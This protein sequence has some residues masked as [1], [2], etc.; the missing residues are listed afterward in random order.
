MFDDSILDPSLDWDA[1]QQQ[2]EQQQARIAAL[3]K[4]GDAGP[5][6][7]QQQ[8]G[9]TSAVTG[10]HMLAAAPH[11]SLLQAIT[12]IASSFLADRGDQRVA[13]ATSDLTNAENQQVQDVMGNLPK[14]TP[15]QQATPGTPAQ[16]MVP[17]T[18]TYGPTDTDSTLITKTGEGTD[19]TMA[20]AATAGTPFKPAVPASQ[21]DIMTAL[22]PLMKNPLGRSLAMKKMEDMAIAEPERQAQ[23]EQAAATAAAAQAQKHEEFLQRQQDT[24]TNL[25]AG[26]EN[27]R[28]IAEGQHSATVEA[29]RLRADA[30]GQKTITRPDGLG[31]YVVQP[32]NG[33]PSHYQ[34]ND[35][36]SLVQGPINPKAQQQLFDKANQQKVA[37]RGIE[38]INRY[39]ELLKNEDMP[40]SVLGKSVAEVKS[41]LGMDT[42][43][44]KLAKQEAAAIA[45]DSNLTM[46][47][48][49]KSNKN[50]DQHNKMVGDL[51]DPGQSAKDRLA[52]AEN[53]KKNFEYMQQDSSYI[54]PLAITHDATKA[55]DAATGVKPSN[56]PRA[57]PPS[58]AGGSPAGVPKFVNTPDGVFP[59]VMDQYGRP[60]ANGR[61]IKLP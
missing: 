53:L 40:A 22:S 42:P 7:A 16:P 31:H 12:P 39:E 60:T 18:A 1:Q 25:Q 4:I 30:M 54:D 59:V 43:S 35:D 24:A 27:T 50:L 5:Q 49:L 44:M 38:F 29:A 36:G 32:V 46:N 57:N 55:S 34:T 28:V 47:S 15:A 8:P 23:R 6:L 51:G 17:G 61:P 13:Q 2:I 52:L 10:A 48:G 11:T 21:A 19:P 56:L 9:W 14:G 20:Q 41:K 58:G 26:R 3:R 33:G 37:Q 45:L